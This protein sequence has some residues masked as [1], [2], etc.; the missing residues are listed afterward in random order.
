LRIPLQHRHRTRIP[1][2][3]ERPQH[4]R[5]HARRRAR[6]QAIDE[7]IDRLRVRRRAELARRLRRTLVVRP[8][9]LVRQQCKL[10]S[11]ERST[12]C[13]EAA[14]TPAEDLMLMRLIDELY[15]ARE[16]TAAARWP[17]VCESVDTKSIAN[18]CNG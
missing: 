18:V 7:R 17:S 8:D 9:E 11:L 12:A 5:G 1:L 6:R 10:L 13:Y 16:S 3:G 15:A 4:R 14:P 2:A